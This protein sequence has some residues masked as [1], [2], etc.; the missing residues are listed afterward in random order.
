MKSSNLACDRSGSCSHK[1]GFTLIELLV[2]IAIIAILA[3]MLL[4]ALGK[5]RQKAQGTGCMNNTHQ[6]AVAWTMYGHDNNDVQNWQN[7]TG[8]WT[9][10]EPYVTTGTHGLSWA[11][12]WED[13]TINHTDNTNIYN[14]T[15]GAIGG[16]YTSK[17]T[18][19]YHCPADNYPAR[20]GA[21][22]LTRV[23]SN[24]MNGFVGDR[25][26]DRTTGVNDW[27]PAYIQYIKTTS[28]TRPGPSM[29]WLLVDEHPDSINDGWLIPDVT[30]T[31]RF[32][33]LPASYHNGAC[34]FVFADS[35]SE[36]HKWHGSTIQP[37][38]MTQY[39]GFAGDPQDVA[40]FV[41]RSTA[42]R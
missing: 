27:Y 17:N 36:I 13:F 31:S 19:I 23:R 12:G 4:P 25:S 14:L 34:G 5:A 2:V 42:R 1:S 22:T 40:W 26:N 24:S 32:V 20:F 41:E 7:D 18:G 8:N 6:L 16:A 38:K 10:P 33:D 39:N 9:R 37:V 35:H 30:D 29:T 11:G 3:A 28:F 15:F 21:T